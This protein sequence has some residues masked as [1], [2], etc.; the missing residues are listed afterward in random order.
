MGS[1]AVNATGSEQMSDGDAGTNDGSQDGQ[2]SGSDN[3]PSSEESGSDDQSSQESGPDDETQESDDDDQSENGTTPALETELN[4]T[5]LVPGTDVQVTVTRGGEPVDGA[6][7]RFNGEAVGDTAPDG[8]VVG[9]VPYAEELNVTV[10]TG[11]DAQSLGGAPPISRSVYFDIRA[12]PVGALGSPAADPVPSDVDTYEVETNATV[13]VANP[14]IPDSPAVVT[15]TINGTPLAGAT[16]SVGD[17]PAAETNQSGQAEITLPADV[18]RTE[19]RVTRGAVTGARELTL[20]TQLNVSVEGEFYSRGGA[21]VIVTARGTDV[22][23]ATVTIEDRVLG[24]TTTNGIATGQFPQT[25]GNITVTATKGIAEG[26]RR[27]KLRELTVRAAPE[28]VL[29]FPWTGVTVQSRLE[30]EPAD[31]VAIRVNGRPVDETSPGGTLNT[32]LPPTYGVTVTAVGYGQRVSTTAGNPGAVLLGTV[33]VGLLVVGA[34]VRRGRRSERTTRGVLTAALNAAVRSTQRLF[35]GIVAF[36]S[37]VDNFVRWAIRITRR[38]RKNVTAI[39]R[40]LAQWARQARRR[41]AAVASRMRRNFSRIA[42]WV[43][44]IIQSVNTGIRNPKRSM[45]LCIGWLRR[46]FESGDATTTDDAAAPRVT[47]EESEEAESRLTVREAWR[48][49][50]KY[51]SV[52][53]WRTKT[54][55]QI[56]RRAIESDDLPPEAVKLLTDSFRGVEYGERSAKD[57]AV[58]AQDALERIKRAVHG[59]TEDDES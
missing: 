21:A 34:G 16:V 54:P 29:P 57:S 53:R 42:T 14:P 32:T 25:T 17:S 38:L 26:T 24:R 20:V 15:A 39:P 10:A 50:L 45:V 30:G 2:S 33:A 27:V 1:A 51:V 44:W 40:F 31:R 11:R 5:E 43:M 35:G 18:E 4:R 3:Q 46:L 23:N 59:E 52:R 9:T 48:E 47:R 49:F 12:P 58:G 22:E 56:S 36:A 41:S 28:S 8:T 37:Q 13:D 55:G 7:V 6:T 19:V